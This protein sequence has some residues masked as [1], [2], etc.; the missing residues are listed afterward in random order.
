MHPP[1]AKLEF[2]PYYEPCCMRTR[3]RCTALISTYFP[4]HECHFRKERQYGPN[5]Y[6]LKQKRREARQ[7]GS[8]KKKEKA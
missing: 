6:D 8:A 7:R 2:C 4:D 1:I 3:G 5:E